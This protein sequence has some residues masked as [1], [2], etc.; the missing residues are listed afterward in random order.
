MKAV[1]LAAL[2][3]TSM[4]HA[5]PARNTVAAAP[6]SAT[7]SAANQIVMSAVERPRVLVGTS[8]AERALGSTV[9]SLQMPRRKA[10]LRA[11][12]RVNKQGPALEYGVSSNPEA[13]HMDVNYVAGSSLGAA[14]RLDYRGASKPS[15]KGT[16]ILTYDAPVRSSIGAGRLVAVVQ[17]VAI[18]EQRVWKTTATFVR[19]ESK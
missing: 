6:A 12:L 3:M 4:A 19:F 2:L 16:R 8:N 14:V 13:Y 15:P 7:A 1:L 9:F 5:A 10:E 17:Q 18:P 11:S